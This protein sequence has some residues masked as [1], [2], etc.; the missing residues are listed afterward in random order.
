MKVDV[1]SFGCNNLL[2]DFKFTKNVVEISKSKDGDYSREWPKVSLLN[3]YDT[4][5]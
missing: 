4:E 2:Q 5:V 3:I 1:E